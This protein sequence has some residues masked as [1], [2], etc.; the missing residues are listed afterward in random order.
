MTAV[1]VFKKYANRRIYDTKK[2]VYVTL[3][4]V[5]DYI[6]NGHQVRIEDAKTKEDVTAFILT[7]IVL[8]QAKNRN[9]LLPVPLLHLV[10]KYGDNLLSEFFEKYFYQ[11]FQN[12]V[13]HK[14]AVDAQFQQWLDMGTN[15][16][17]MARESFSEIKPFPSI[18]ETFATDRKKDGGAE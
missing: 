5:A 8:E 9:A 2:S 17:K 12:F 18:F 16:S 13:M 6:R 4:E 15:L 14:Q 10:I 3:N 7:Q 11:T 1:V